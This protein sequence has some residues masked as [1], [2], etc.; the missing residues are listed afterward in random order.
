MPS[1][2]SPARKGRRLDE[3]VAPGMALGAHRR[4]ACRHM[5]RLGLEHRRFLLI[6]AFFAFPS[7][8]ACQVQ[9]T[10]SMQAD[11]GNGG[12]AGTSSGDASDGA[13]PSCL[14]TLCATTASPCFSPLSTAIAH[15]CSPLC[16]PLEDG[17]MCFTTA[18]LRHGSTE[19][20]IDLVKVDVGARFV[21]NASG[22]LVAVCGISQTTVSACCGIA[23]FDPTEA[24]SSSSGAGTMLTAANAP[25]P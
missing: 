19:T 21:Y 11:G 3:M 6:A 22:M 8:V 12:D 4:Y 18:T 16:G 1:P 15:Y 14:E 2:G 23:D 10:E 20:F 9:S 13:V 17:G 24:M 7:L 25:C 5:T